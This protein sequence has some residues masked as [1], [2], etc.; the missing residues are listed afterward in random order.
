MKNTC[1][2]KNECFYCAVEIVRSQPKQLW[3]A[4]KGALA[5]HDAEYCPEN[6][7][8]HAHKP[9]LVRRPPRTS[10]EQT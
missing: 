1:A 9:N 6:K 4:N 7:P 3:R 8:S 10:R 5:L 2:Q